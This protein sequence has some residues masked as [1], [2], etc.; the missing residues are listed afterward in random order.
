MTGWF[1]PTALVWHRIPADRLE[2]TSLLWTAR[3]IG[4]HVARRELQE[5]GPG[6]VLP[7]AAGRCLQSLLAHGPKK[8]RAAWK[9]D[10]ERK[11]DNACLRAFFEGYLSVIHN[12]WFPSRSGS[13][14]SL[15]FRSRG[16]AVS[17]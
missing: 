13:G 12:A 9:G 1:S 7:L 3:R 11:L 14:S 5:Q 8:W 15:D 2:S 4:G 6:G 10:L 17:Q 16:A